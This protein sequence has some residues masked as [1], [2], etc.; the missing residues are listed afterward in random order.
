[1]RTGL[2]ARRNSWFNYDVPSGG[3]PTK[4]LPAGTGL[5]SLTRQIT[6]FGS[7]L[8]STAPGSW[9]AI[10]LDKVLAVYNI[11]C[12]CADVP[13][14]EYVLANQVKRQVDEQIDALYLSGDFKYTCWERTTRSD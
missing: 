11:E 5:A 13:L 3:I 1:M 12:H 2:S 9:T 10:D 14:S 6:G 4:A 8:G 7:G